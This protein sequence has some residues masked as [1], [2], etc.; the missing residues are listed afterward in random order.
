MDVRVLNGTRPK[1]SRAQQNVSGYVSSNQATPVLMTDALFVIIPGH[2]SE[3]PIQFDS[4]PADHGSTLP[5]AGTIV[6]LGY[7]DSG[8]LYIQSWEGE[9]V[10]TSGPVS[11]DVLV[12]SVPAVTSYTISHN[13]GRFPVGPTFYDEAGNVNDVG[14]VHVTGMTLQVLQDEPVEGTVV[15][16]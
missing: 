4:W 16:V 6:H 5:T 13:L 9:T 8:A 15:M 1:G 10:L 11:A 3:I 2:S 14:F 12:F 7:D